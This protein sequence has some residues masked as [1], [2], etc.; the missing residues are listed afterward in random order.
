MSMRFM[1]RIPRK[2]FL[3]GREARQD[4][5]TSDDLALMLLVD[6]LCCLIHH[7]ATFDPFI[8]SYIE[9]AKSL[10]INKFYKFFQVIKNN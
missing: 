10:F 1:Y 2:M 3:N 4:A 5:P 7:M 8:H 6:L 9:N